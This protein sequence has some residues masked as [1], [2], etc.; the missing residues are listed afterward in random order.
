MYSWRADNLFCSMN[1]KL[2]RVAPLIHLVS[3]SIGK[4]EAA[5]ESRTNSM[6]DSFS[7]KKASQCKLLL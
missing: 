2:I 5:G 3:V 1:E 4:L 7:W 6:Y